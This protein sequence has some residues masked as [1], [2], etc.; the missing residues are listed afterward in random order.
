CGH[1]SHGVDAPTGRCARSEHR[2]TSWRPD[3]CRLAAFVATAVRGSAQLPPQTGAFATSMLANLLREE[4]LLR[5]GVAEFVVCHACNEELLGL[6]VRRQQ[7][8]QLSSVE[9]GLYDVNRC[10]TPGCNARLDPNLAYR[11][12][13]KHWLL[14]PAEWGGQYYPAHRRRCGGCG[15]LF[16]P[17]HDRCPICRWQ[18]RRWD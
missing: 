14:V 13:R 4:H 17:W 7:P 6:A 2:L 5:V 1:G 11:I 15:N 9:H 8:I 18:V 10:P 3:M 16:M 12:G